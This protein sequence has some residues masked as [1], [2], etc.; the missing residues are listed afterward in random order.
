MQIIGEKMTFTSRHLVD[1]WEILPALPLIV[2]P[3]FFPRWICLLAGFEQRA[4]ELL[5][6][7][8]DLGCYSLI[9]NIFT[10]FVQ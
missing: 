10:I 9:D 6:R 5:F 4:L 2:L 3:F 8:R 1:V 7:A